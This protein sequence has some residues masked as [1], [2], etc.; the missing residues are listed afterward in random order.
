M[1]I[2]HQGIQF[3][4]I[5]ALIAAPLSCTLWSARQWETLPDRK[6]HFQ[7]FTYY[8]KGGD[9]E[10]ALEFMKGFPVK[11]MLQLLAVR[12]NIEI[13]ASEFE[14]FVAAEENRRRLRAFGIPVKERFRWESEK[15]QAN[16]VEVE[17]ANEFAYEFDPVRTYTVWVRVNGRLRASYSDSVENREGVVKSLRSKYG[18][19]GADDKREKAPAV[20]TDEPKEPERSGDGG[21]K[22]GTP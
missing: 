16:T 18:M 21:V 4:V 20:K 12:H 15:K 1:K 10:T 9:R 8:L 6:F 5:I 14:A 22:G 17:Y 3:F 19:F 7:R 11:E 13:D 2:V